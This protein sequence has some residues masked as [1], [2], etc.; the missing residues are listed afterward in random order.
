MSRILVVE[1]EAL[2]AQ[3]LEDWLVELGFEVVGPAATVQDALALVERSNLD[4]AILDAHLQ[5][6]D[7]REVA[8]SLRARS[9]P[10][11]LASGRSADELEARFGDVAKLSKPFDFD[12][13]R[14]L[15]ESL[16]GR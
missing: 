14:S 15:L 10:F 7:S 13:L 16:L 11:A 4:A 12:Q 6:G 8:E 9:V 5:D 3:L 1:D 2:I